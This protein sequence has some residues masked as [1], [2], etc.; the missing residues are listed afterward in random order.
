VSSLFKLFFGKLLVPVRIS[1]DGGANGGRGSGFLLLPSGAAISGIVPF[2]LTVI[3]YECCPEFF[4]DDVVSPAYGGSDACPWFGEF[5]CLYFSVCANYAGCRS[6]CPYL[7][8]FYWFLHGD[9]VGEIFPIFC[10]LALF[11]F[12]EGL[13]N[14]FPS[15]HA[16]TWE[17]DVG[18]YDLLVVDCRSE[19]C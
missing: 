16:L 19:Y 13:S 8:R 7:D 17:G 6:D 4:W 1:N 14:C 11:H 2:A 9:I 10:D 3:A 12:V 18:R 5:A 15:L